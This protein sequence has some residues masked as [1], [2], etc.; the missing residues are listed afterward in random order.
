VGAAIAI[1]T[2]ACGTAATESAPG[3]TTSSAA[4]TTATATLTATSGGLTPFQIE[5]GIGPIT[6]AVRL[7]STVDKKMA[8]EGE[9]VFE[10]KC[11]ACHKM[12]ERYVGPALGD[13]IKRR[14]PT[15]VMNMALNPQ[16]MVDNHP[17]TKKLLAE[18]Y[19]PMPN[20]NISPEQARQVVEY[21]RTRSE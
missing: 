10:Q 2:A 1:S 12:G 21:L 20:Q 13:V 11:A 4:T 7:A 6:E 5:H 19:T 3:A 15:F 16:G 8:E 9:E 17:E 14:G 18:F